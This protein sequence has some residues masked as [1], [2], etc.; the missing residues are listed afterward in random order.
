MEDNSTSYERISMNFC[1]VSCAWQVASDYIFV[2]AIRV[3][4]VDPGFFA[5]IRQCANWYSVVFA[6]WQ[7]HCWRR[8]CPF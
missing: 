1:R 8:L 6:R 5:I 2:V 4:F 3:L 7:H